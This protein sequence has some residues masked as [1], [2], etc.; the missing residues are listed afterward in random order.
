[1][2]PHPLALLNSLML[3]IIHRDYSVEY[4]DTEHREWNDPSI[5]LN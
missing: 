2:G 5:F 3:E 4:Q 1:M